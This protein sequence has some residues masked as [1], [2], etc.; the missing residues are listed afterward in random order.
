M[1]TFP[2]SGIFFGQ[3]SDTELL[4]RHKVIRRHLYVNRLINI[5]NETIHGVLLS[6]VQ[7]GANI[8][9]PFIAYVDDKVLLRNSYR[10]IQG[11]LEAFYNHGICSLTLRKPR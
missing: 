8:H 3:F 10:E 1:K 2:F 5:L 9:F 11:L 4:A 6:G 7:V